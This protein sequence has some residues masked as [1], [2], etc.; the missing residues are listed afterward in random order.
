[1]GVIDT[2]KIFTYLTLL[3]IYLTELKNE[4]FVGLLKKK[5]VD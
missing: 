2:V 4:R 1:M 5:T 3:F